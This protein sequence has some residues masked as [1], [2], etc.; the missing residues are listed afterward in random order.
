VDDRLRASHALIPVFPKLRQPF[1]R[2]GVVLR[3]V[4]PG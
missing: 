3:T 4:P 1:R 2:P